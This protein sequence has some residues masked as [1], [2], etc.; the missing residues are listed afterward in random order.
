MYDNSDPWWKAVIT[1][2][3]AIVTAV[4]DSLQSSKA[5]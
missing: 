1:V 3:A 4:A 5:K 2:I